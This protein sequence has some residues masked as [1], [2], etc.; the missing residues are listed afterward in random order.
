MKKRPTSAVGYKRPISQ[1]AR[2]AIAMGAHSR[3]RVS[4]RVWV[5]SGGVLLNG[6]LCDNNGKLT[7]PRLKHSPSLRKMY[8]MKHLYLNR[9]SVCL[10]AENIMFLELDMTPPNTASLD[11]SAETE[12]NQSHSVDSSPT[13]DRGVRKS[14]SWWAWKTLNQI[15]TEIYW[16]KVPLH[17]LPFLHIEIVVQQKWSLGYF[18]AQFEAYSKIKKLI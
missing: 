1:Y 2:V 11:R 17:M 14:R 13:K 3:Y 18:S 9:S 15:L 7:T 5:C 16:D 12:L 8:C 4:V 10:Q 6:K